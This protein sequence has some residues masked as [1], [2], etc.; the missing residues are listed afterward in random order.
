[1]LIAIVSR[2]RLRGVTHAA[3]AAVVPLLATAAALGGLLATPAA[4]ATTVQL[5]QTLPTTPLQVAVGDQINLTLPPATPAIP[6]GYTGPATVKY[7][8]PTTSDGTVLPL[9]N[10]TYDSGGTEHA[11]F[12][13]A[14]AG[15]AQIHVIAPSYSY[16]RATTTTSTSTSATTSATTT[17]GATAPPLAPS[18]VVI[19]PAL[20][21]ATVLVSGAGV[22]GASVTTP[23][24]G[25][26]GSSSAG[27]G[28]AVLGL[29][30]TGGALVL[31]RG[32]RLP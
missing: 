19:D 22:Q 8:A 18:C 32:R 4:A 21:T 9:T 12:Q 17:T 14:S 26:G 31:L 2:G 15:T 5:T 24:T 28:I 29:L 25:S 16:C 10:A 20:Q 11:T 6:P 30:V 13:A 3:A 27:L 23:A 1:M 7:P